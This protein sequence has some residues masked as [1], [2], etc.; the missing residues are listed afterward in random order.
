[1]T[2][3]DQQFG[4]RAATGHQLLDAQLRA[5]NQA[6]I[7]AITDLAGRITYVN[8]K[9]CQVSGYSAHE[10][11]GQTHRLLKSGRH[12]PEFY[13][14]L[15][16]TI[17]SGH[18]WRGE[19]CNRA[20][21]GTTYWVDTS[22]APVFD[23]DK[24]IIQ[25]VAVR[26]LVTDRK[27]AEDDLV[28][29]NKELEQFAYVA[30]HDLQTPIRHIATYVGFLR[31]DLG[32][33]PSTEVQEALEVIEGA[34]KR[35]RNLIEDM[36]ALS[37]LGRR[38]LQVRSTD[39]QDVYQWAV[40]QLSEQVAAC[41]ATIEARGLPSWPCDPERMVQVFTNLLQNALK[42]RR[43]GVAPTVRIAALKS[44]SELVL[45]FADNGIGIKPEYHNRIFEIFQRLHSQTDYEGSGIGLSICKKIVESHGG[46]IW[47][48]SEEGNG[49]T[50]F[51][52]IPLPSSRD[53]IRIL[54]HESHNKS[55][56]PDPSGGR[57]SS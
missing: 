7:V 51:F 38:K 31:Q 2:M 44:D 23:A 46:R 39:L 18:E 48:E 34:T 36:L 4:D 5:L 45:S 8:D 6:A 9:F 1:M 40:D 33:Q 55:G 27:N 30:S 13:E 50:F 47:V 16:Q 11:I 29:S 12:A 57:R 54:N 28:R 24:R 49:T 37:R 53:Q 43:Q 14:Q 15:W 42:F 35:M 22:I 3:N 17:S 10:L 25:Y 20:K 26:F 56:S 52:S 19:V 32:A 41:Q 21:D